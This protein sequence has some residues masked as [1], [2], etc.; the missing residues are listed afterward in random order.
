[1]FCRV[2]PI[3]CYC[4]FPSRHCFLRNLRWERQSHLW[5]G[6]VCGDAALT[7]PWHGCHAPWMIW[8]AFNWS[9]PELSYAWNGWEGVS[10]FVDAISAWPLGA[11]ELGGTLG[12]LC[13]WVAEAL[14]SRLPRCVPSCLATVP[15]ASQLAW[16]ARRAWWISWNN[17][18]SVASKKYRDEPKHLSLT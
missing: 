7:F 6:R 3:F 15:V 10:N 9:D 16:C 11:S 1:M 14:K 2:L 13:V 17:G 18:E 5:G 8:V 12:C 4:W